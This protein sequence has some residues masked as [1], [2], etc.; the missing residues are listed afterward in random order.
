MRTTDLSNAFNFLQ[1]LILSRLSQPFLSTTFTSRCFSNVRENQITQFT[2]FPKS[3]LSSS[4]GWA[5][6]FPLKDPHSST[7]LLHV[8]SITPFFSDWNSTPHFTGAHGG[9]RG[10]TKDMYVLST[11]SL[12]PP[13][14]R[15]ILGYSVLHSLLPPG[16]NRLSCK[17]NPTSCA[18]HRL[19]C[20]PGPCSLNFLPSLPLSS[21]F[22]HPTDKLVLPLP[23]IWTRD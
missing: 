2:G 8:F 22:F 19:S 15:V 1:H 6:S 12:H 23:P 21:S 9:G 10:R 16:K 17:T 18:H 13:Q 11:T 7:T 14:K 20:S 4:A 5:L 3:H